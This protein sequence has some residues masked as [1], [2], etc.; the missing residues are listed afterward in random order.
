MEGNRN[1]K[2]SVTNEDVK[3]LLE[4]IDN[5]IIN[6][7]DVQETLN[8]MKRKEILKHYHIWQASNGKYKTY[9]PD[10]EKGRVI[11]ER[12]NLKDL[13]DMIV[14]FDQNKNK[15]DD[16]PYKFSNMFKGFL[17]YKESL[18]LSANTIYKYEMDYIRYLS[19]TEFENLDIRTIDEEMIESFIIGRIEDLQLRPKAG[20][21]LWG[22]IS[23]TFK[24]ARIKHFISENPCEYVDTRMFTRHYNMEVKPDEEVI[25]SD[26]DW[27]ALDLQIDKDIEKHPKY[28]PNYAVKLAECT[29]MRPGEIAALRW[30]DVDTKKKVL[31]ICRSE[32][33]NRKTRER[34]IASTKTNRERQFPLVSEI[35][36]ILDTV[37]KVEFQNGW[38]GEFVFQNQNGRVNKECISN[39][40]ARRCKQAGIAQKYATAIRKTLNSNLK[41]EGASTS[42][43][44]ALLGNSEQVNN[45]HYT[46]DTSGMAEKHDLVEKMLTSRKTS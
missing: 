26:E 7:A 43:T 45:E 27:L 44:S 20:K 1:E 24:H 9:L 12:S 28:I 5:G 35:S 36:K 30:C 34:E 4:A 32:K 11:K 13:K 2:S 21:E 14:E 15:P 39:C 29:G 18:Q 17:S 6:I 8:T 42:I 37:K 38:I 40:V 10:P 33:L 23:G 46:Y 22:L 41:R 31:R 3:I 25:L 19:G 16:E